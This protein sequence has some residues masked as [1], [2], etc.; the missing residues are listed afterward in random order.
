MLKLQRDIKTPDRNDKATRRIYENSR[1]FILQKE[2]QNDKGK[3]FTTTN[4][5]NIVHFFRDSETI[6]LKLPQNRFQYPFDLTDNYMQF[7]I[8]YTVKEF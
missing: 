5:T 1:K 2:V 4:L 8:N 6:L 3:Y 7:S